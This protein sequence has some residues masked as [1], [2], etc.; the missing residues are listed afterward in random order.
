MNTEFEDMRQQL[1]ILKEKLQHQAIVNDQIFRRSMKRNVMSINRR[2]TFISILCI[3]TI[4][5]AYWAFVVMAGMSFYFWLATAVLLLVSFCYT[6]YN[7]RN[8][9][10][11]LVERD[12]VDARL[13]VANAKKLDA[14]W[15]KMGIPLSVLWLAYF[16]Y[17]QYRINNGSDWRYMVAAGVIGAIV[18]FAIGLQ[19]HLKIQSDYEQIINEIDDFT[20]QSSLDA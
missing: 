6:I 11:K 3:L 4:P 20:S 7:G 17:E 12:L 15:L 9:N 18:G 5:Y 19:F 16:F 8:L 14:D 13:K 10:S 1:N 2:Y